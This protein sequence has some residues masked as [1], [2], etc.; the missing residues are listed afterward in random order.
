M[1]ARLRKRKTAATGRKRRKRQAGS[2]KKRR[3]VQRPPHPDGRHYDEGYD[4]GHTA[5]FGSGFESGLVKGGEKDATGPSNEER[6]QQGYKKGAADGRYEGGEAIVDRMMPPHCLLPDTPLEAIIA[7][8][9]AAHQERFVRLMSVEQVAE[10][11]ALALEQQTPLSVVRLGD[12][13]LLAMA[14][15][16]V[17]PIETV[18]QEGSFL[19]YAGLEVPN[20]AVRDQLREA[21]RRAD[22]VGIP[23]LRQPNYQLLAGSVLQAHGIDIRSR[24]FADSLVN[25]GL[26]KGGYLQRLLQGRRVLLIGNKADA[27]A[28]V[29]SSYGVTVA[30]VVTPVN[31]VTDASRAAA[32]AQHHLFDLA[33]VSAGI[34][35]V[36]IAE[37]LARITGKV[38]LDF[39]HMADTIVKGEAP[40]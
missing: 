38:A 7:A 27:L 25:Y 21:V 37:E 34:S 28:P 29:L 13:E 18:R 24:P 32:E 40:F 8:G 19:S 22:I 2:R 33:L 31:G 36:L 3:I 30:G 10:R 16:T 14:Q 26:Y 6:F 15:E 23:V 9:I 20:L 11:I 39:G 35:A 4:S 12:G 1:A 5:G 17:M